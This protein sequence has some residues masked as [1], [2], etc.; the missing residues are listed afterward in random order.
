MIGAFLVT[1]FQLDALARAAMPESQ[2]R[3][4]YLY[5]DEFQNFATESFATVF[6]EARKYKLSLLVANQYIA[7][8]EESIRHAIFGNVGSIISFG[9]GHDDAQVMASQFK[10]KISPNDLL[11]LGRGQAY[12]RLMLDGTMT[13]PFSMIS[14]RLAAPPAD[15]PT[16][17]NITKQS[18]ERY[19]I[20]ARELEQSITERAQKSFSA[21]EK[22][23]EAAKKQAATQSVGTLAT[24][25]TI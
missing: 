7:Q 9:L 2:R 20:P 1:K 15:H 4:F 21:T 18:R 8:L 5:I 24:S 19:A 12:T 22:A 13:D 17:A 14:H 11:S 16:P 25:L 3:P 23:V 10:Q 6:S